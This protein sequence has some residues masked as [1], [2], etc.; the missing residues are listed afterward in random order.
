MITL[1]RS[2]LSGML[3]HSGL[4]YCRKGLAFEHS[5]SKL[6]FPKNSSRS[7]LPCR[8]SFRLFAAMSSGPQ[9]DHLMFGPY[10]IGVGEVFLTTAH[11]FAFVN[12]RPVVPG[13]IL[14]P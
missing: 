6:F 4:V 7:S 13:H 2:R 11:S 3:R 5:R 10:K 1:I 12:L 9:E 14:R 8:S